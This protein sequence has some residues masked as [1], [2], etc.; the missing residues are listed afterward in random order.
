MD[1]NRLTSIPVF[2]GLGE[3]QQRLLSALVREVSV[4]AGAELVKQGDYAYDVSAIEEGEAEVR[5]DGELIAT[6]GPGDFFGE[7]GVLERTLRTATVVATTPMRLITLTHWDLKR[8]PGVVEEIR[9]TLE[10]RTHALTSGG[11]GES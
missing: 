10:Q 3:D 9:T 8:A 11:S 1:P 6:L 5:R 4:P 7:I 2:E